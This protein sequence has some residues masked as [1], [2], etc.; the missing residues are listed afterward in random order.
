MV[1]ADAVW[2][3]E[4]R[5][6]NVLNNSPT[7]FSV[8]GRLMQL[9]HPAPAPSGDEDCETLTIKNADGSEGVVIYDVEEPQAFIQSDTTAED[10]DIG[11]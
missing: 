9:P 4:S 2:T 11:R 7:R 5:R 3:R 1:E 10:W 6:Q 8:R